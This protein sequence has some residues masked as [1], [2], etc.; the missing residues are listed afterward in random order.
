[1]IFVYFFIILVCLLVSILIAIFLVAQIVAHF[2][3]DAPFV[4]IQ[5]EVIGDIVKNLNLNNDS[6]LYDL[7]CGDGRI[8]KEA[9]KSNPNVR[10]VGVE[11][12]IFPYLLASFYTRGNKNLRIRREDIFTADVSD[13]TVIF[14]Y[15]FPGVPDKLL[16]IIEKQCK[17]GVRVI[18]CDFECKDRKPA[19]VIDLNN[20]NS[21]MGKKLFVYN[22]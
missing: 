12:A 8:L 5:N 13:A 15:L 3:T 18:S 11:K 14:F 7:G 1:M 17:P 16:P 21:K 10:V 19:E 20:A 6:V 2:T 22:I 4:P 9:V